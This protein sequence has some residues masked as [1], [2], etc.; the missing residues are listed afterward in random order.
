MR[1]ILPLMIL[2]LTSVTMTA[3]K[4]KYPGERC[5]IFRYT[6]RDK[7]ATTYSLERPQRFLSRRSLERR[8]RQ[9]LAVDSTDLPVCRRYVHQFETD[10]TRILGTS[11][12]QNTVVVASADS[13][14]LA[15][16]GRLPIVSKSRC[17]FI[18]P[19]SIDKPEELRLN[20]HESFNKWDSVKNDPLGMARPQIEM[21]CGD[22]LHEA[23]LRGQGMT[24]AVLDGGFQNYDRIPALRRTRIE[25]VHDFVLPINDSETARRK[26]FNRI[27]HGTKVLSALAAQAPE[28]TMGTAPEAAYWLLRCEDPLTEQPVE[29][30]YWTMAAEWADSVGADV[31]NSSLGYYKYDNSTDSYR[32]QDLDGRTAFVSRTASMLAQKGIVLCNS[33]GNSGMGQWKKIGVPADATDI[34]TVGAVNKERNIATF[35]SIG[36]SQDQRVKPDVVA[37]GAGTT[38]LSGRGT[39]VH[40]MGTSFSTPVVCGLVACLWQGLRQKT[41]LEIIDLVRRSA[42]QYAEPT[43]IYGYGLPNFWKAYTNP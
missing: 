4:V 43:N 15:R 26:V 30:D 1:R 32:L 21:L 23:G 28:V 9:G 41:A 16:L 10:D 11:R 25:G 39:L 14:L 5:Y 40:D 7:A 22:S 33:A 17:V 6:L 38:L 37:L 42:D 31:I 27:D 13:G 29:E 19:D 3:A 34:L 12:W 18:A 36:P 24:I 20:V 2:L 8:Q 35:S